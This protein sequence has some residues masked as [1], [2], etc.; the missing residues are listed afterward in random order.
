M[1]AANAFDKL[2]FCLNDIHIVFVKI[3]PTERESDEAWTKRLNTSLHF[4][5]GVIHLM[6]FAC[7][8]QIFYI[9]VIV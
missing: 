6:T 7:L 4:A 9:H 5:C 1:I 8:S 3:E 2:E